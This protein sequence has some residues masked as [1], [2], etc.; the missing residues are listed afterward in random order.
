MVSNGGYSAETLLIGIRKIA[1]YEHCR[2]KTRNR[3]CVTGLRK[4]SVQEGEGEGYP[5]P[6]LPLSSIDPQGIAVDT[7]NPGSYLKWEVSP[8]PYSL[9]AGVP[10][11]EKNRKGVGVPPPTRKWSFVLLP[12]FP[13]WYFAWKIRRESEKKMAIG[14]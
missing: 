7:C 6:P 8:P 14:V 11:P 1:T 12:L 5:L 3:W 4:G 10:P 2:I 13:L 9:M